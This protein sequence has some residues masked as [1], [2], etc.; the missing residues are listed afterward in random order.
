[1]EPNVDLNKRKKIISYEYIPP[2]LF[3]RIVFTKLPMNSPR[4]FIYEH[5]LFLS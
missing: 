3:L 5:L 2:Y 1:M 4:E